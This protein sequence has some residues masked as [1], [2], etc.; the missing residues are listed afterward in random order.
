MEPFCFLWPIPE[1]RNRT[2]ELMRRLQPDST[3]FVVNCDRTGAPFI[4][5]REE[6][7]ES[8][9]NQCGVSLTARLEM[10][11]GKCSIHR[12]SKKRNM[13]LSEVNV[14][15]M[16]APNATYLSAVDNREPEL[17]SEHIVNATL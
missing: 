4:H 6:L 7:Q 5:H 11:S 10:N 3:S 16:S 1:K 12:K 17:C 2:H 9:P 8:S 13:D 15:K 14:D